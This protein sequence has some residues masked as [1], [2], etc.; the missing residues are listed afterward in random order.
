[1][2]PE[3]R[4][5]DSRR[6]AASR[7]AERPSGQVAVGVAPLLGGFGKPPNGRQGKI[8]LRFQYHTWEAVN[9]WRSPHLAPLGLCCPPLL[10][11][12]VKHLATAVECWGYITNANHL[13]TIYS[14]ATPRKQTLALP[15]RLCQVV[16]QLPPRSLWVTAI[17][18]DEA[19]ATAIG[20]QRS[21]DQQTRA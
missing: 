13:T 14:A 19:V 3:S 12:R 16:F 15:R 20:C 17:A 5:A 9:A 4:S 11:P 2:T 21:I 7:V 1:M 8:A 10:T 6:P 18:D